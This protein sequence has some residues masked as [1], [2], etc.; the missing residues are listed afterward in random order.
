M[1]IGKPTKKLLPHRT[2][3]SAL[4]C[5]IL[6][7]IFAIPNAHAQAPRPVP[8]LMVHGIFDKGDVFEKMSKTLSS[9]LSAP[10]QAINLVPN[11]GSADIPELAQQVEKAAQALLEATGAP[12]LDIVAFSMGALVSRYF[13]QKGSG[14]SL[15]RRFVSI[16]GPHQGTSSAY[17][18]F[19]KGARSMRF[20][21]PLL[22]ELGKDT[23]P[24][25]PVE[26]FSFWTPLDLMIVPA[27]SSRLPHAK[28]KTFNVLLHP[29]M[30]TND[31]VIQSVGK[32]LRGET[33]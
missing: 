9:E 12:K 3:M 4:K 5:L 15:V 29:L 32:A 27:S 11:D 25:G 20:N 16:S 8:V 28:E 14:K 24:W 18:W 6:M 26:V 17:F 30:L 22:Q 13:I 10:C 23:K 21:S 19:N 31:A 2:C 7:T 33:L 1:V